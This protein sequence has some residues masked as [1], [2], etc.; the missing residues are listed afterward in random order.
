M[1][2]INK[3][4]TK[5]KGF[6]IISQAIIGGLATLIITYLMF[7]EF[8]EEVT[9]IIWIILL[10]IIVIFKTR[11]KNA[12]N[13]KYPKGK[14]IVEINENFIKKSRR[15]VEKKNNYTQFDRRTKCPI[16]GKNWEI[17]SQKCQQCKEYVHH[18]L[19][20]DEHGRVEGYLINCKKLNKNK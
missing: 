12:N 17:V 10:I 15:I 5:A 6:S 11:T 9:A 3:L 7:K 18:E 14:S 16:E 4:K 19:I 1:K 2:E 13:A 8:F 20:Q